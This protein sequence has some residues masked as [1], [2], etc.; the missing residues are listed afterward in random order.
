MR[1]YT[2][3]EARAALPEV[4][5]IVRRIRETF[6]KL[7]A[8]QAATASA[9]R[10]AEADGSLTANPW[11]K[12]D[13][14]RVERLNRRLRT[15][16]GRLERL[17]VELKDPEVGLIDFH[18][19]RDGAVVYLCFKLGETDITHWHTLESGFAGRQPL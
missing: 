14:N 7:R 18:S 15:D 1:L 12:G 19:E 11:Q 6:L 16:A 2:V 10:V 3:D 4:I 5:P 17:G 9:S 8:L 13:D